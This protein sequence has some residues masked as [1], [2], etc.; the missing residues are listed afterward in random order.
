MNKTLQFENK[1]KVL[2]E[3]NK[4]IQ[5]ELEQL[6]KSIEN[7]QRYSKKL[8]QN[9]KI[10]QQRND[11]FVKLHST[12]KLIQNNE[13]ELSETPGKKRKITEENIDNQNLISNSY[14]VNKGLLVIPN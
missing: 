5:I 1:N 7:A 12:N 3:K 6:K 10:L 11:L 14:F 9:Y 13:A 8:R 4:S 2:K